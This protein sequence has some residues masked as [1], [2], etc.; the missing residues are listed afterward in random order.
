[1]TSQ[2]NTIMKVSMLTKAII[3]AL[4]L[5]VPF[6]GQAISEKDLHAVIYDTNFYDATDESTSCSSSDPATVLTGN[7]NQQKVYNFFISKGLQ[8]FQSAGIVG[9]LM[10]ESSPDLDPTIVQSNGVGHGIA[11]WSKPGRWDQL[12][13]F[14][15]TKSPTDLGV[16][17]D[18]LFYE[19]EH[20]SPYDKT[21]IEMKKT[22]TIED[23]TKTFM[24]IFERPL[25]GSEHFDKRLDY[26]KQILKNYGNGAPS[27][28][29]ISPAGTCPSGSGGPGNVDATGYSFPVA[30]QTKS[31]NGGVAGLSPMPCTGGATSCHHDNTPALDLGRKPGGDG[32]TG[33]AVYAFH[34]GT[35]ENL[36]IYQGIAGCYS[37]QL[38]ATDSWYYWYGHLGNPSVK[39]G[40]VVKAGQQLAEIGR[41][42]CT[43]N[44]S[45]PHL[46]IDRGCNHLPGGSVECRDAGIVDIMNKLYLN[47]PQ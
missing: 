12:V 1:M 8:P 28:G 33:A 19:A 47:L 27:G 46:H 41:R 26:A 14:A 37:L 21:I 42:A 32:S 16:Q 23:A 34:D 13:I 45:L 40:Q 5:L 29:I 22:T 44:G 35:I 20:V 31:G 7:D 10:V 15:K 11:Q 6:P 17:L 39:N 24:D 30:P 4:I 9:N 43:G 18:F 2:S 3:V 25:A 36:H 38:K